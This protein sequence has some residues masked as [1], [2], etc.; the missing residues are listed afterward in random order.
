MYIATSW[1]LQFY[2]TFV[3]TLYS[4]LTNICAH[5]FPAADNL[6][7]KIHNSAKY[8]INSLGSLTDKREYIVF[9]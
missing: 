3:R 1:L 9:I 8:S 7:I 6:Y 5:N 4:T 2:R